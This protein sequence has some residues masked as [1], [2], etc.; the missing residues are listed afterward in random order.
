MKKN[1]SS[2]R[3]F[4]KTSL[5]GLTAISFP[6]IIKANS[7]LDYDVVVETMPIEL[8]AAQGNVQSI[9]KRLV[10]VAP[11][12]YRSQNIAIN[13]IDLNLQSLPLSPLG[14]VANYTGVKKVQGFRGYSDEAVIKISMTKPLFLTVLA[15]D[16]GVSVGT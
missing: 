9:K 13:D 3:K 8:Q 7:D 1:L 10:D 12:L 11:I 2:R 5:L 16:Y 14:G 15:L 6:N 4:I